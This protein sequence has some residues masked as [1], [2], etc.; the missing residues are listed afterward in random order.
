ML[1]TICYSELA[2]GIW[3]PQYNCTISCGY[4]CRQF[5][6]L[7]SPMTRSAPVGEFI[8]YAQRP[9]ICL[10]QTCFYLCSFLCVDYG[11][12]Y[13]N[14]YRMLYFVCNKYLNS[15]KSQKVLN[16]P[17]ENRVDITITPM[18]ENNSSSYHV[19]FMVMK[20]TS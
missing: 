11:R 17:K 1:L 2:Y 5:T 3:L 18:L 8:Q 16:L 19:K 6:Y 7:G 9:L 20:R 4:L 14:K 15:T 10:H 12:R 13:P